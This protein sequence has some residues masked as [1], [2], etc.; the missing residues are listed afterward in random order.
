MKSPSPLRPNIHQAAIV[1]VIVALTGFAPSSGK[2]NLLAGSARVIAVDQVPG[3][4]PEMC[5]WLPTSISRNTSAARWQQQAAQAAVASGK[6]AA[7]V[8]QR[9][10]VRILGDPYGNFSAVGLDLV[11]NEVI[12]Q[13]ENHFRILVYDR[14]TNTPPTATMSE[15]KR[16]IHGDRTNLALNCAIYVDPKNGDIYT[17]NNDSIDSTVIFSRQAKGN[18]A[19]NRQINT[20]H[21]TFG[22]AVDE[23][24]QELFLTVQHSHA[25]LV[26]P[27]MASGDDLPLRSLQGD[28]TGLGDPHGIALDTRND[29]IFVSN[30]GSTNTM[31]KDAATREWEHEG[32]AHW[33]LDREHAV[34][35]SGRNMPPSITVYAKK[36]AGN[37][38][39]LRTIQGPRTQLNWPAGMAVDSE[40]GELFVANDT[41]DSILVFSTSASGDAAPIRVLKGPRTLIRYPAGVTLDLVNNELWVANFG[42]HTATVY[43]RDASGDAPP[44]RTI[45]SGP[46]SSSVPTLGNPFPV[47]FDTKRGEILVPN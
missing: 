42:N 33:P 43:R 10:P 12:L 4:D 31:R 13:D 45:R 14:T 46:L 25:V 47:A 23:E 1:A 41:G 21:G 18:V 11:N 38:A 40:R 32:K 20:P 37:T 44:L 29:L 15:P 17:V 28:R 19:P 22:I 26:F 7:A 3:M 36:A 16:I 39:P 6:N 35:G 9:R 30:F 34:P 8:A 24:D 27:K 2:G 5:E